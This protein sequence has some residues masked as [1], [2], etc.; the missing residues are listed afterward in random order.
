[1]S[2]ETNKNL[3]KLICAGIV[4]LAIAGCARANFVDSNSII[5]DNIEYYI[6]TNKSVYNLGEDVEILYRITNLTEE[7]WEV[8]GI[9]SL[10][11]ILVAPNGAEWFDAIWYWFEPAPP[12]LDLIRLQ[13]NESTEVSA[14][15]PQIDTQGTPHEP[16]DDT[17]VPPGI[18]RITGRLKPT[19]TNVDVD[20]TIVPEPCS[21]VL[22]VGG[23][24][25]VKIARLKEAV[26]ID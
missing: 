2:G 23:L 3:K 5:E 16:G 15:W 26:G 4:I 8:T 21:L 18:Y 17:Q 10:R 22:F 24:L 19:N 9:A 25:I 13:P 1:M 20:I 7:E 6:Q 12:G 14:V 11:F